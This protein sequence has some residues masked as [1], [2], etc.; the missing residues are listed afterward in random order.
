MESKGQINQYCTN[1]KKQNIEIDFM[2]G[3]QGGCDVKR[4]RDAQERSAM[5]RLG[6]SRAGGA[7]V[8]QLQW[9]Q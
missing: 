8:Q 1:G 6:F 2:V 3:V 4:Q 9:Q 5:D 7:G